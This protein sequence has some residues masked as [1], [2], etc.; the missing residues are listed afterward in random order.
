MDIGITDDVSIIKRDRVNYTDE[1]KRRMARKYGLTDKQVTDLIQS[2]DGEWQIPDEQPEP[3]PE[4]DVF[5]EN[6]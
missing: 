5:D 1:E 6:Q 4:K 3:E 2:P